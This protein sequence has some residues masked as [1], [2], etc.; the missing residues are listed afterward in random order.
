MVL[1]DLAQD[2]G[3][4]CDSDNKHLSFVKCEEFFD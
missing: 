1:I 4:L 2:G 3:R